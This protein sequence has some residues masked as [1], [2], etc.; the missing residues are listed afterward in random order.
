MKLKAIRLRKIED[1]EAF[2]PKF[3]GNT[4]LKGTR[5]KTFV[6]CFKEHDKIL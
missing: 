4:T 6:T 1:K 2:H 3:L 5:F